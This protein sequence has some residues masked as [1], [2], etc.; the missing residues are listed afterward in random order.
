MGGDE[1][2]WTEN[3]VIHQ[4]LQPLLERRANSEIVGIGIE[5]LVDRLEPCGSFVDVRRARLAESAIELRDLG[6]S[7]LQFCLK[8]LDLLPETAAAAR[9]LDQLNQVVELP[10]DSFATGLCR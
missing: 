8:R 3:D 7:G 1:P 6:L 9:G 2:R 10:L 4:Q 5:A